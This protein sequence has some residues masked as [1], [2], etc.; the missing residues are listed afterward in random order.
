[1]P[2]LNLRIFKESLR[3]RLKIIALREGKS[4]NRLVVDVL[5]DYADKKGAEK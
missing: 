4:L 3:V 5:S 1:M 2:G